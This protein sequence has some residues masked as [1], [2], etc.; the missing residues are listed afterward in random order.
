M[1]ITRIKATVTIARETKSLLGGPPL[2]GVGKGSLGTCICAWLLEGLRDAE[3]RKG[4]TLLV[5]PPWA[6]LASGLGVGICDCTEGIGC[7]GVLT[8]CWR[9]E[10]G[11]SVGN[12]PICC[13]A[14]EDD[15]P[16]RLTWSACSGAR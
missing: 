12:D 2:S 14:W 16:G 1:S 13:T 10:A 6:G 4:F 11:G 15:G 3:V 9:A 5:V 7:E 8:I